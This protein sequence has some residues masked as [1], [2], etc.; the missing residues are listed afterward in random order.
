MLELEDI[1]V[2]TQRELRK[3]EEKCGCTLHYMTDETAGYFGLFLEI[4]GEAKRSFLI[5]W[6]VGGLLKKCRRQLCIVYKRD[7]YEEICTPRE[8]KR[9]SSI[10]I[11]SV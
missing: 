3:K 11:Q 5:L 4:C 1:A 9:K 8:R 2:W 7:K 10:N 6:N